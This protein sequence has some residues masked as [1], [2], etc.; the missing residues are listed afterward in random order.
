MKK[1]QR[2]KPKFRVGQVVKVRAFD[3]YTRILSGPDSNRH[4]RV[5]FTD[6]HSLFH[7]VELRGLT[8]KEAGR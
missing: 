8:R 6:A 5:T 4:Y 2:K 1:P 7:E 3:S